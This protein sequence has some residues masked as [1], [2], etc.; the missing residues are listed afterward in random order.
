MKYLLHRRGVEAAVIFVPKTG[1]PEPL[2][3]EFS[4]K[5]INHSLDGFEFGY[6]GSGP[7]Q[8]AL[9]ILLHHC[10]QTGVP[11]HQAEKYHA[12]FKWAFIAPMPHEGGEITS[13]LISVW[14]DKQRK[15]LAKCDSGYCAA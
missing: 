2:T 6:G 3:P 1:N 5:R 7:S 9:A 11:L 13:D 8:T 15:Q 14:L 4:Q 12:D 10:M